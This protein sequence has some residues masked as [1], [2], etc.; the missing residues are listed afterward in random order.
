LR[1]DRNGLYE[2]VFSL[3][4]INKILNSLPD[5]KVT[6]SSTALMMIDMQYIDAH[7][8]YGLGAR[9]KAAGLTDEVEYYFTRLEEVAIPNIRRLID[10]CRAGG[11]PV[12]HVR[13]ANLAGDSSDTSWRYKQKDS[14]APPGSKDAEILE[15]LA[16][17]EGE[18]IFNKTTSSVFPSSHADFA[19]RNM[20]ID[21][22]IMTG[23]AT[24]NCVES[25]TR[26]GGDLGYRVLLVEDACADLTPERHDHAIRHLHGN[27]AIVKSTDQ[28]LAEMEEALAARGAESGNLVSA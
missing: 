24:A 16:P 20:G 14:W 4:L 21:T 8:D 3:E 25:S 27:Y 18:V 5:S 19:L 22:L 12:V 10:A 15:E 26:G 1:D 23:V 28:I 11:L 2:E 7:R 17:V 13:I 6:A 9:A